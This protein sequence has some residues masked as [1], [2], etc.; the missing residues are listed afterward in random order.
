MHRYTTPESTLDRHPST[1]GPPMYGY[2]ATESRY[3]LVDRSLSPTLLNVIRNLSNEPSVHDVLN[4][5]C[6]DG[7]LE[8]NSSDRTFNYTSVDIEPAA[9]QKLQGIFQ[10][11]KNNQ[12][13]HAIIGDVTNLKLIPELNREFDAVVS[14]RVLHGI[15]PD[16]YSNFFRDVY[17]RL[18]F[19][20]S[21]FISVACDQDWKAKALHNDYDSEGMNDCADVMFRD[22]GIERDNPFKV[23]FFSASELEEL[24][25]NNGFA[26][27]E[28]EFFQEPS[29]YEHLHDKRNTYIFAHFT[30]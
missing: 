10:E 24:G 1:L 9:V 29:G 27:K 15:Q 17:N 13:N 20:S 5:G 3:N 25:I 6:G 19:D 28:M 23:H 11:Q 7:I 8:L 16:L 2:G 4:L 12:H 22:F 18:A 30:K 14:W 26:V 21:F